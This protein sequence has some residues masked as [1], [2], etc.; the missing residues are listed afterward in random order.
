[1][2]GS[3]EKE[4]PDAV[5]CRSHCVTVR[6]CLGASFM[7]EGASRHGGRCLFDGHLMRSVHSA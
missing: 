4:M 5:L 2:H 1:M 6:V 7:Q 3:D